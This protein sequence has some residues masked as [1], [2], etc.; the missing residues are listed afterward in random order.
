MEEEKEFLIQIE[1]A[2]DVQ[3]VKD[4]VRQL[5]NPRALSA[6]FNKSQ[7]CWE[8]INE[9]IKRNED[10]LPADQIL[11]LRK[12]LLGLGMVR[13]FSKLLKN[14]YLLYYYLTY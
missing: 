9:Y 11:R 10:A 1:D 12:Y 13:L 6:L 3:S 2:Q 5:D 7:S 4:L 8:V 14:T